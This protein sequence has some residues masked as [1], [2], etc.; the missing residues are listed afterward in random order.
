MGATRTE[1]GLRVVASPIKA[2]FDHGRYNANHL[3]CYASLALGAITCGECAK[4][5]P[6]Q[7]GAWTKE[8][9]GALLV[10]V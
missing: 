7:G 8:C 6:K 3:A 9:C 10:R 5:V 4:N 2:S 1:T